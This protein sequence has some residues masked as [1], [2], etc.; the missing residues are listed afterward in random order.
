MN[1]VPQ[2]GMRIGDADRETALTALGEHM[3]A[4][5]IDLD[6]YG[7]RSA[8]V[9]AAK[10]RGELAELF[11]DLPVP[12]PAFGAPP[13]SGAPPRPKS[14]TA[15]TPP[16][17]AGQLNWSDRPLGQ[18]VAAALVPL[19][20]IA[21]F[22]LFFTVGGWWWFALPFVFTA[23][24]RGLWGHEWEQAQRGHRDRRRDHRDWRRDDRDRRRP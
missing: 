5:R 19:C 7:E 3:S 10:T 12:H 16:M 8:K 6:E 1:D 11:D 24:G 23:V 17:P 2:P 14:S 18:R 21:G 15:V 4:G 9:T 22:A 20:W 13:A